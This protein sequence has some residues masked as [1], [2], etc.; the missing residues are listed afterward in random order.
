MKN[1]ENKTKGKNKMETIKSKSID[2]QWKAI[3]EKGDEA[4]LKFLSKTKNHKIK[5]IDSR[6]KEV[7][8]KMYQLES[9]FI[10]EMIRFMQNIMN[11]QEK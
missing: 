7:A 11:L 1:E 9:D 8:E 10:I 4:M 6:S 3:K 2:D 5:N